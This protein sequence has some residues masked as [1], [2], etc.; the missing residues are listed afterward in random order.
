MKEVEKQQLAELIR[1]VT[2]LRS[3]NVKFR[4]DINKQVLAINSKTDHKHIPITLEKDILST[5]QSSV[6]TAIQN[7]LSGHSSPL[8]KLVHSVVEENSTEIRKIIS[9]SF[10]EVIRKDEFKQ[11]IVNAFSHKVA[12][13]IIS[14]NDGLFDK[15]AN[16]L[17]QDSIFKSKMMLAV[18]NIVDECLND[19]KLFNQ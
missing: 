4:E 2:D 19:K 3:E 14:N 6:S 11:S 15:V 1:L 12:R 7:V 16:E 17:K 10:T 13:T 8:T 5:V 9:D 18:S